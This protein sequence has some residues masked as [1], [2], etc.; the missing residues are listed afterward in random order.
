MNC[1]YDKTCKKAKSSNA[2][3]DVIAYIFIYFQKFIC[4]YKT[5]HRK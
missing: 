3:D 5:S 2:I 1:G 4:M